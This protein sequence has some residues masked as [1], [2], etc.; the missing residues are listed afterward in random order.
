[1]NVAW[2]G[3]MG[4]SD[5]FDQWLRY[6]VL[7]L[8]I[9]MADLVIRKLFPDWAKQRTAFHVVCVGIKPDESET[10]K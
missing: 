1:M 2:S 7:K 6:R 4:V 10:L 3:F 5:S 8:P 9:M